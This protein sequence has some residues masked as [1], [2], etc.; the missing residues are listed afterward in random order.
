MG[1]LFKRNRNVKT[2]LPFLSSVIF[3][4]G[5]YTC[6]DGILSG[7]FDQGMI[8]NLHRTKAQVISTR[9]P[10]NEIAVN[11]STYLYYIRN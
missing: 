10:D 5:F 9:I 7:F 6:H 3:R 4:S 1:K 8:G 2:R 11:V